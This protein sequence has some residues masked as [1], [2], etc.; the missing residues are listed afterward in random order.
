MERLTD[1]YRITAANLEVRK[2][3]L[4]FTAED[5]GILKK[6]SPW[7]ERVAEALV[8]EF[9]DHQ[10]TFSETRA[11]FE[12]FARRRGLSLEQVRQRLERAQAE[13]FRQIFQEAARGGDYGQDYFE[14][15]LRVGMT[16][17]VIDLP[18]KW[19]VG[20][21]ALY[22]D[23]IRKYLRRSFPLRPQ[24]R[25]RAERAIFT[26]FNYDMQAVTEAFFNDVLQSCGADLGAVNVASQAHDVSDSYGKVKAQLREA[27]ARSVQASRELAE[28]SARVTAG[29]EESKAAVAQIAAAVGQVSRAAA[30]QMERVTGAVKAVEEMARGAEEVAKGAQEQ[31][32]AVHEASAVMARIRGQV[33]EAVEKV[34]GMG[35]R[36]RQV[37]EIASVVSGIADQ[38]NLLALNAAI[39]AAR[40]GEHGKGFAVVAEEVRKLAERSSSSAK[41]IGELVAEIQESVLGSVQAMEKVAELVERE[42]SRVVERVSALAEKHAAAA[43]EMAAGVAEIRR[44]T[45]E[46]AGVSE[47]NSAAAQQVSGSA[48]EVAAQVEQVS[49]AMLGLHHTAEELQ[50]VLAELRLEVDGSGP[51]R[52]PEGRGPEGRRRPGVKPHTVRPGVVPRG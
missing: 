50:K 18:L 25:E 30:H 28:V 51:Q 8:K 32:A 35:G 21:Y 16:H 26:V 11:F 10:F 43:E 4:R 12:D 5:V 14:R 42:M 37:L 2:R 52:R 38:T 29:A 33:G 20:S 1:T 7:A 24:F 23:L 40:A 49:A 31:A 39:E 17:N 46:M 45:E 41:E 19:Y 27:L 6:L 44:A 36:S 47:E 22:Q 3:F 48:E 13:Y 34:H 15:R 9:Y